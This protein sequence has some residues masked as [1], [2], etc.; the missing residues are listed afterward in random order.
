MPPV[1]LDL[2]FP[3]VPLGGEMSALQEDNV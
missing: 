1:G 3:L 2:N